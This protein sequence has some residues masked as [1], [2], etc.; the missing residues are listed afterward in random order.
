MP[1]NLFVQ[2]VCPSPKVW[3]FNEKMLH[4]A[5]VARTPVQGLAK[6]TY[7]MILEVSL[8]KK[9]NFSNS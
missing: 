7:H 3:D 2:I 9:K 5:F 6:S 8:L 1:P 4:W